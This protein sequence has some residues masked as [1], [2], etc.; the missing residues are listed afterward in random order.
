M[1][2]RDYSEVNPSN[3]SKPGK[4]K[5]LPGNMKKTTAPKIKDTYNPSGDMKPLKGTIKGVTQE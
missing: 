5:F 1:A 4:S 3:V 2:N